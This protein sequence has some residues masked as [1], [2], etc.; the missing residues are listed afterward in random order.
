MEPK[1]EFRV[2]T[3]SLQKLAR[4]GYAYISKSLNLIPW[5]TR[6]YRMVLHENGLTLNVTTIY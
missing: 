4:L 6:N 5:H 1:F 2:L 3:A